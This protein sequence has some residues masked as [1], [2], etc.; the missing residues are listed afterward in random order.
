M[1]FNF[2][3]TTSTQIS[4]NASQSPHSA[5]APNQTFDE[6]RTLLS[7][8]NCLGDFSGG[9]NTQH[10]YIGNPKEYIHT[11]ATTTPIAVISNPQPP[12]PQSAAPPQAANNKSYQQ[13]SSTYT[14]TN[15][16]NASNETSAA[17]T[18]T[19]RTKPLSYAEELRNSCESAS[20][21]IPSE[22]CAR[23]F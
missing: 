10:I 6:L 19:R 12:P 16:N 3:S 15:R 17:S 22:S 4:P 18:P 11:F 20:A 21:K 7:Y 13:F 9:S 2:S 5:A 14:T 8:A 23:I 1:C